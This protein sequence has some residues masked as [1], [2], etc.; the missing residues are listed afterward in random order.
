MTAAARQVIARLGL[1]PLPPEGGFFRATWRNATASAILY[2]ITDDDFSALHRLAQDEVWHFCAGDPIEHVQLDPRDGLVRTARLGPDILAGEWPQVVVPAGVW[3]GARRAGGSSG[4]ALLGC[5]VS[6]PW[7][8]RGF[9]LGA[10][11]EL[12]AAFPAHP[13]I[14]RDFTR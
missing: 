8:E 13:G 2:L 11:A 5:T 7:D 3:Q 10:R 14:V 4:F 1:A 6:P 9:E 12:L